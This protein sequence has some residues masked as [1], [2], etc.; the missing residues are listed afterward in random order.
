MNSGGTLSSTVSL[1][2]PLTPSLREYNGKEVF[3]L[4]LDELLLGPLL[5]RD[6]T[7]QRPLTPLFNVVNPTPKNLQVRQ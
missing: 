5:R 2:K 6:M 7:V 3:D 4:K 1:V